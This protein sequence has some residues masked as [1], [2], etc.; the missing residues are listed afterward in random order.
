LQISF[1]LL[2]VALIIL[3]VGVKNTRP[4]NYEQG[5]SWTSVLD[6]RNTI[7]KILL[8]P[9][10]KRKDKVW[11]R[12]RFLML[13]T[14]FLCSVAPFHAEFGFFYMYV[15]LRL[16]WEA[17]RYG[18]Y[19]VYSSLIGVAGVT[20]SMGIL[21]KWLRLSDPIVGFISGL[22]QMAGSVIYAFANTVFLMYL[23][24][25]RYYLINDHVGYLLYVIIS[26]P[27]MI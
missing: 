7:L 16:N 18:D 11:A 3:L 20:M 14:A 17:G 24:K 27:T 10:K 8:L 25:H 12:T 19:S 5:R 4:P 9:L 15:R 13:I 23:G 21:S 2:S 1:F 26:V 6:P 22:S